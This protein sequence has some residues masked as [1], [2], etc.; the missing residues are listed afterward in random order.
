MAK[1]RRS[2]PSGA[3]DIFQRYAENPKLRLRVDFQYTYQESLIDIPYEVVMGAADFR[4]WHAQA[5]RKQREI[6]DRVPLSKP[7]SFDYIK[8]YENRYGRMKEYRLNWAGDN[9]PYARLLPLLNCRF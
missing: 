6:Y 9:A 3:K 7:L 8:E 5:A 2:E 1:R 4:A